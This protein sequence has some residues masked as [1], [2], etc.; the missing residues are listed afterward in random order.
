MVELWGQ[1]QTL[2]RYQ[3]DF[4]TTPGESGREFEGRSFRRSMSSVV[5]LLPL[6]L[7]PGFFRVTFLGALDL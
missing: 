6:W 3:S 5:F 4:V 1:P 7:R 2:S